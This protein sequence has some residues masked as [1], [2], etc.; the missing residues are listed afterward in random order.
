MAPLD[1][2]GE[3]TV[4]WESLRNVNRQIA[5]LAPVLLKLRSDDVYHVGEVPERNH[6]I[7]ETSLIS[8]LEAGERFIIGEFTHEDG[9]TWVMIVNKHL[10]HSAFCRPKFRNPV[11][12]VKYLSPVT[13]KI[14]PFPNPWY[15]LA[16]GQGVLL[17]LE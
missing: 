6:G 2:Y 14:A 7:K 5:N 11:K 3:K 16:P 10:K 12:A 1:E 17:K 15:A 8:G 13:G 4:T 9:S